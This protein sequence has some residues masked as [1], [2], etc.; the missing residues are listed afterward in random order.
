MHAKN[1]CRG[2]TGKPGIQP[3]R[4]CPTRTRVL[5]V[6]CWV[7]TVS[8]DREWANR[9]PL[10]HKC[11]TYLLA[12]PRTGSTSNFYSPGLESTPQLS[13]ENRVLREENH[14]LQAQLSHVS[15]GE[16]QKPQ[17]VVSV[18]SI[19]SLATPITN[20]RSKERRWREQSYSDPPTSNSHS[21][22]HSRKGY[23]LTMPK[24]GP[25]DA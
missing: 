9:D 12:L 14:R 22:S 1:P 2:A 19:S 25:S 13:N 18:V 15:R 8:G 11:V 20:W 6:F 10:L 21:F 23:F 24:H 4:L 3:S 17:T 5:G 16:C 7:G